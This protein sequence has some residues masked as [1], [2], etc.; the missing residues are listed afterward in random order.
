M[1]QRKWNKYAWTL[2]A[3]LIIGLSGCVSMKE[4]MKLNAELDALTKDFDGD[5]VPDYFDKEEDT[6]LDV[7]VDGNGRALD[8]D[9]DEIPDYLDSDPFTIKGARV[10]ENGMEL[11]SDND[12]VLDSEDMEP[13]TEKDAKVNFQGK[14]IYD[15]FEA[16]AVIE[17][18]RDELP[19][20][21][22]KPPYD[23][24]DEFTLSEPTGRVKLPNVLTGLET[25]RDLCNKLEN[26]CEQSNLK[27]HY[28]VKLTDVGFAIIS[29]GHRYSPTDG[30]TNNE[31]GYG[32]LE[33]PYETFR[34]LPQRVY[35]NLTQ[36]ARFRYFVFIVGFD[37]DKYL[38]KKDKATSSA[39]LDRMLSANKGMDPFVLRQNLPEDTFVE[40][41]VYE[42]K[43]SNITGNSSH[44]KPADTQSFSAQKHLEYSGISEHLNP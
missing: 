16:G 34:E 20:S 27:S 17:P 5:G 15:D 31:D 12:G 29:T 39:A 8:S 19:F 41:L 44:L 11:D 38:I 18:V 24:L 22:R 4:H 26:A 28:Y 9:G 7:S 33:H 37:W 40:A 23:Y 1:K 35:Y 14:T 21:L 6:P 42:F 32:L 2:P 13:N 30:F 36:E 25:I 10:D 43:V 3:V